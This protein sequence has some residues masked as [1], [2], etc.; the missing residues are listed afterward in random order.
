MT[1]SVGECGCREEGKDKGKG[2][3]GNGKGESLV[4]L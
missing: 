3:G 4:E 1:I 2:E